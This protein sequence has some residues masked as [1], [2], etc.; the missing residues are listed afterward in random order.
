MILLMTQ[1]PIPF[2]TIIIVLLFMSTPICVN[3]DGNGVESKTKKPTKISSNPAN[4]SISTSPTKPETTSS[5][6]PESTSLVPDTEPTLT[7]SI[8]T[9]EGDNFDS[10]KETSDSTQEKSADPGEATE[11]QTLPEDTEVDS[12][13]DPAQVDKSVKDNS[14]NLREAVI[15]TS[16]D[17]DDVI[18]RIREK[19]MLIRAEANYG[20]AVENVGLQLKPLDIQF[21]G[22]LVL[23]GFHYRL[24]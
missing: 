12:D 8:T 11:E 14:K 19:E 6:P 7:E 2:L 1:N 18:E 24:S 13:P 4:A 20:N 15:H 9:P 5:T 17:M 21:Y 3:G 10:S 16:V 23:V 22:L